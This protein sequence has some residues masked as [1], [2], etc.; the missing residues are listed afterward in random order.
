[1]ALG[2]TAHALRA[3]MRGFKV[4]P[5]L[6]GIKSPRDKGWFDSATK[7]GGEIAKLFEGSNRYN[8]GISTS[9]N[10][11]VLDVDVK[12]GKGGL[13]SLARLD[14]P[15]SLLDTF[16]M[17]TPS[18]GFHYY[19]HA[20]PTVNSVEKL[21]PGLDTRGYHGYVIGEG[22][23]LTGHSSPYR[24]HNDAP[25]RDAPLWLVHKLGE[26]RE[27]RKQGYDDVAPDDLI[28]IQLAERLLE[29]SS[30]AVE[31]E[32]GN[33]YAYMLAN[34]LKDVG[35]GELTA[36]RLMSELWNDRCDPPFPEDQL[37]RL[38]ANAY[39]YGRNRPGMLHPSVEFSSVKLLSP[40]RKGRLWLRHGEPWNEEHSWLF[41]QILP[42]AGVAVLTGQPGSGKSFISAFIAEKLAMGAMFFGQE[43]DE[44][45]ATI[46]IA[47]EG[48]AS[49]GRRM[50]VLGNEGDSWDLPI[51]VTPASNLSD[52]SSWAELRKDLAEE[53]ESILQNFNMP[54]RLI[55]LDTLSAAGLIP[56]EN[57]NSQCAKAMKKLGD[58]AVEFDCLVL[59]LHHPP[60]TGEG[61]RGGS[62]LL[63][64]ADYVLAIKPIEGKKAKQL[65]LE[66]ARDADCPRALGGFIIEKVEIGEDR[67]GRPITTG[68][69]K[70]S[71]HKIFRSIAPIHYEIFLD[72]ITWARADTAELDT[73]DPVPIELVQKQFRVR[74]PRSTSKQYFAAQAH[75]IAEERIEVIGGQLEQQF[76]QELGSKML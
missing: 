28:A 19:F 34:R 51:S 30:G 61:L 23:Q 55:I 27:R 9:D 73:G 68:Y 39:T 47:A 62:A 37:Q 59:L 46:I 33:N 14:L 29:E 76:I 50:S 17:W 69:I 7:N 26:P 67:K 45:G 53:C 4:F 11:L 40:E 64:S 43:P 60:K 48:F 18:G 38:V 71:E 36:W 24:I 70:T 13:E 42:P 35:V 66:K 49:F 54:V 16:T 32:G 22:S 75:A 8:I 44:Q 57:D 6:E 10:L 12:N 56:D 65:I 58:L 5:L 3:A 41:Y 31:N 2:S 1:M 21:G 20:T 72:S 15:M 74:A 63:G 52:M 25:I